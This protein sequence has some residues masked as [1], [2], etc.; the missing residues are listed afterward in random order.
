MTKDKIK[1][2]P[3]YSG[4]KANVIKVFRVTNN[5]RRK[6]KKNKI[7]IQQHVTNKVKESTGRNNTNDIKKLKLIRKSGDKQQRA[8]KDI[9]NLN[10]KSFRQREL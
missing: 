6:M 10:F 3:V 9:T 8:H 7:K 2:C 4:R 1:N 5:K